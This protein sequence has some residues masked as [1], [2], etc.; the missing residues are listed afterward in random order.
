MA[1]IGSSAL[2]SRGDW[3]GQAAK[4]AGIQGMQKFK[5]GPGHVWHS[6]IFLQ[7]AARLY[8]LN[9]WWIPLTQ[10]YRADFAIHAVAGPLAHGG[11]RQLTNC[12]I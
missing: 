7:L 2:L 1:R 9:Y 8:Y 5:A 4:L 3:E 10:G 11:L 6:L 12:T